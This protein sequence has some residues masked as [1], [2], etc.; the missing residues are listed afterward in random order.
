MA[1]SPLKSPESPRAV[2]VTRVIGPS[3]TYEIFGPPY[4]VGGVIDGSAAI[5]QFIRKAIATARSRFMIY[6]SQYG[7]EIADLIGQDTPMELL[8]AEVPR[9]IREALIY[10]DRINNVS[11]FVLGRA[12]DQLSVSFDVTTSEGVIKEGVVI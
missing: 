8:Q 9:I 7:C 10:D 5:R 1:L 4:E 11:N 6:N 2:K 12:G 3:K